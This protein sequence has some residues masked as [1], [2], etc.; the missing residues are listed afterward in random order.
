MAGLRSLL[1]LRAALSAWAPQSSSTAQACASGSGRTWAQLQQQGGLAGA[2]P[3]RWYST[4][5][6]EGFVALNNIADNPGA[7]HSVRGP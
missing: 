5:V 7:T 1:S 4:P 2:S 6:P 3:C